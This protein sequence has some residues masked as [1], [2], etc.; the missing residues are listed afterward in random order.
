MRPVIL[1]LLGLLLS[2]LPAIAN[3]VTE[4]RA[5]YLAEDARQAKLAKQIR[6]LEQQIEEAETR[7]KTLTQTRADLVARVEAHRDKLLQL[8]TGYAGAIRWR[9]REQAILQGRWKEMLDN[10]RVFAR[11][12]VNQ[13]RQALATLSTEIAELTAKRKAAQGSR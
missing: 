6:T 2:G 7:L 11:A 9:G 12:E 4:T 5:A 10:P 3:P 1:A 13:T 8:D